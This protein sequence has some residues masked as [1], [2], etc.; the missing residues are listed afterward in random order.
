MRKFILVLFICCSFSSTVSYASEADEV[1]TFPQEASDSSASASESSQEDVITDSE[2]IEEPA[3]QEPESEDV[4]EPTESD[5]I[6]ETETEQFTEEETETITEEE[7]EES[8]TLSTEEENEESE[9]LSI[10]VSDSKDLEEEITESIQLF[11][12]AAVYDNTEVLVKL[13]DIHYM[14]TFMCFFIVVLCLLVSSFLIY[15]VFHNIMKGN[16]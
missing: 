3:E 13:G 15:I 4:Q 12:D 11:S 14:L 5:S 8:E 7:N 2:D 1:Q 10:D 9:T 16:K 6:E